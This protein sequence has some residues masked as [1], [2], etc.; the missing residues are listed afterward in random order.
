MLVNQVNRVSDFSKTP[1]DGYR[2]WLRY[3]LVSDP[4]KLETFRQLCQG[5]AV[6]GDSPMLLAAKEEL[7][8]GLQGLLGRVIPITHALASDTTFVAGT[9]AQSPFIARLGL[10]ST[11]EE[12]GDELRIAI[13]AQDELGEVVAADGESIEHVGKIG[14][15][16]DVARNLAHYIDLEST[17]TPDESMFNP[18]GVVHGGIVCTLLDSALGC[19]VHTT[20]P[21]GKGYTSIEL[22]RW[23]YT[24]PD[25]RTVDA[26]GLD[27]EPVVAWWRTTPFSN[28]RVQLRTFVLAPDVEVLTLDVADQA[29]ACADPPPAGA[30]APE[31]A[32]S[33]TSALG[34]ATTDGTMAILTYADTGL[35]SRIRLPRGC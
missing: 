5:V 11:I 1:E 8:R 35:V 23:S 16:R 30:A 3:D 9:L 13:D 20:L 25:G 21:A 29:A 33:G 19:A 2:L 24:G 32:E 10:S 22:Y 26:G 31:W 34:E 7:A 17:L 27:A 6:L 14:R 18:I 12:M 15:E 28:L 4:G